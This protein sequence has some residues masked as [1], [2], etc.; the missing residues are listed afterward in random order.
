MR[1]LDKYILKE[2]LGPFVFGI[3]AFSGVFVGTSTIF[4]IAK[5]MTTYGAPFGTAV[6]LFI[7]SLPGVIALT[8]PMSMLL[9][10]LLAFGRLSSTSEITA[11]KS[12]G[13]S[14]YRLTAP[15]FILALLVSIFAGCFSELVVPPANTAYL[16]TVYFEVQKNDRPKEQENIVIKDISQGNL[17]E[18]VFARKFDE[19]GKT[20]KAVSA[21]IFDG[22]RLIEVQNAEKADWQNGR[23]IM[24]N[25]VTHELLPDGRLGAIKRFD[26]L[27]LPVKKPPAVISREQ[28]KPEEMTVGELRQHI[29]LLRGEYLRTNA[30]EVE[31]QQRF[32]IPVASLVFAL[33]GTPLGLAPHRSS[34]SI[35][36]G[37]SIGIIFIYYVFM[38]LANAL[39]QG[40]ALSPVIAVWIPNL[41]GIASGVYLVLRASR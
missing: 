1:I 31:L 12:A 23:W 24:Y 28:K 18:L 19:A 2:L 35:G 15:V 40:G 6:K 9:A 36:F 21:Q 37:I 4:K 17:R 32:S 5:L 3:A 33:I 26:V 41:L 7:Y 22:E 8:F 38:A 29:R 34:S 13:I 14:F 39:G 27:E 30:Y 16:K 11:M 10:S 20:M 25:G